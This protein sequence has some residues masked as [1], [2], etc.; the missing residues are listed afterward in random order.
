MTRG[1]RTKWLSGIGEVVL[2][3]G[4]VLAN[5]GGGVTPAVAHDY[6]RHHPNPFREIMGKLNEILTKLNNGGGGGAAG[7]YTIRWDTHTPSVSRFTSLTEFDGAAVRDNDTGLVWEQ[8]PAM[9]STWTDARLQ[10]FNKAVPAVGGTRGWRLPTVAELASLIDQP[11][12]KGTP[13]IIP[14][15]FTG[16]QLGNYWSATSIADGGSI[17]K[18]SVSFQDGDVGST[19]KSTTSYVWCVRG[20]MSESTY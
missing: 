2:I 9:M 10:C 8:S 12:G 4:L 14:S 18:Y 1:R 6:P 19:P 13:I 16:V 20:S 11:Q 5:Y 3:G 15:V 17:N 7:N